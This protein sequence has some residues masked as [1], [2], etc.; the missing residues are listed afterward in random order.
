M[1][2]TYGH[3]VIEFE[4]MIP[5]QGPTLLS[6]SYWMNAHYCNDIYVTVLLQNL[7]F[8]IFP[9]KLPCYYL[10]HCKCL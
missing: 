5:C 6:S 8:N 2:Q 7:V 3:L 4:A 9:L 1:D 10:L